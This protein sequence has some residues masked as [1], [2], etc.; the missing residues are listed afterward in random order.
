M[1]NLSLPPISSASSKPLSARGLGK[2][3]KIKNEKFEIEGSKLI[4]H[5]IQKEFQVE[6]YKLLAEDLGPPPS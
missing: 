5:K 2:T 4:T 3:L 1:P 6:Q